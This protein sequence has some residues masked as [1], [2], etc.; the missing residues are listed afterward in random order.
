MKNLKFLLVLLLSIGLVSCSSDDDSSTNG[1][2]TS[3]DDN[4][5]I[6]YLVGTGS[7]GV[8]VQWNAETFCYDDGDCNTVDGMS[9]VSTF[10]DSKIDMAFSNSDKVAVGV[11]IPSIEVN[12]GAGK[13]EIV[14]GSYQVVD[15]YEE[16]EEGETVFTSEELTSGDVYTL[17]YGELE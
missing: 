5:L 2:S 8:D 14:R 9:F 11:R 7:S 1:G 17:E 12:S 16:L 15:G 13:I 3:T 6:V 4:V 10:G